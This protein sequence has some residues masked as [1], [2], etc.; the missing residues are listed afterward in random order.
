LALGGWLDGRVHRRQAAESAWWPNAKRQT[1][2]AKRP[3]A[4]FA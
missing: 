3:C 1:P 2:N 4:R